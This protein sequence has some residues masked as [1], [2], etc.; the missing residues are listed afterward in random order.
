MLDSGFDMNIS[1]QSSENGSL[2]NITNDR[3]EA[4]HILRL[5]RNPIHFNIAKLFGWSF[6]KSRSYKHYEIPEET[7]NLMHRQKKE[8]N[9]SIYYVS[10]H[11]SLWETV[12]IPYT[13]SWH[14]G[15]IPFVIMGNN[16][17]QGE[18]G[19]KER[20]LLHFLDRSGVV[21][22][23]RKKSAVKLMI[24]DIT[25]ILSAKPNLFYGKRNLLIFAD[26]TRSRTGKLQDFKPAVFEGVSKAVSGGLEA[27]IVPVDVGY[28]NV[29]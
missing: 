6:V 27:Y 3:L 12:A 13:I 25:K 24:D 4:P 28:S 19:W 7:L 5:Y 16:L 20:A 18:D 17:V 8:K 9:V 15:R 23:E 29:I 22:M 11:K 26:G 10:T 1:G 21:P 14:G 2:E